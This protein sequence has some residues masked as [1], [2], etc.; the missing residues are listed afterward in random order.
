MIT[1]NKTANDIFEALTSKYK[2]T[3]GP[4]NSTIYRVK[5][6]RGQTEVFLTGMIGQAD[7][8]VVVVDV[9]GNRYLLQE[10]DSVFAI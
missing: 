10:T 5:L 8:Q 3:R 2:P 6:A 4:N 1:I 7:N 9:D